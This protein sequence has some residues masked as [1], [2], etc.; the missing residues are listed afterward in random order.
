M[1]GTTINA[2][3]FG[4]TSPEVILLF[5]DHDRQRLHIYP[6]RKSNGD[7][8]MSADGRQ[9][10]LLLLSIDSLSAVERWVDD[11]HR[12][13]LFG[14]ADEL[15]E[16]GVPVIDSE[17][18]ESG[19]LGPTR[20][21]TRD[22]MLK[23][24]ESEAVALAVGNGS[25]K[26]VK[27]NLKKAA[28][29]SSYEGPTLRSMLKGIRSSVTESDDFNF[30]ND[31]GTPTIVRLMG[32]IT[33]AQYK[34]SCKQMIDKGGA[35]KAKVKRLFRWVEGVDGVGPELGKAVDAY[36]YPDSEDEVSAESA[37]QAHGVPVEDVQAV[38]K[39]YRRLQEDE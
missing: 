27:R 31:V 16:M 22:T 24:I 12:V 8:E 37:A 19:N 20:R 3:G 10:V 11:L 23:L 13:L 17:V 14:N 15:T 34:T 7:L 26:A 18:D 39:V 5:A 28:A 32:D 2:V 6:P 25:R 21:N 1:S 4:F 9:N 35:D 36:L 29:A 38:S 30:P 33:K